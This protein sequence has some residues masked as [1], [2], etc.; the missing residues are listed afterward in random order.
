MTLLAQTQREFADA[1]LDPG[2]PPPG[3]VES[4]R[5][6]AHRLIRFNI[7]RNNVI[8]MLIDLVEARYPVVSRL[9]GSEFFRA[10]ARAY[11]GQERPGAAL[12]DYGHMFPSFLESF[13][14]VQDTP[15]LPGVARIEWACH[16]AYYAADV[17]PLTATAF[18]ALAPGPDTAL[19]VHPAARVESSVFPI[20]TIWELNAHDGEVRATELPSDGEAVLV[21]RPS[22]DVIVRKIGLDTSMFVS[23]LASGETVGEAYERTRASAPEFSLERAL[24]DVLLAGAIAGVARRPKARLGRKEKGHDD[25]HG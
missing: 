8:V 3:S 10:M 15:Y 21:T 12:L 9:T 13:E 23:A 14:P 4:H 20:H 19:E 1:V 11:V 5:D 24:R 22:C 2:L 7:Y 6:D 25:R 16:A 17:A 18:A